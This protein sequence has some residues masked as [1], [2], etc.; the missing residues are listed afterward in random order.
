MPT[1]LPGRTRTECVCSGSSAAICAAICCLP[2]KYANGGRN[3]EPVPFPD[4]RA[5]VLNWSLARS[6]WI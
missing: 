2:P 1:H 4:K 3:V 5:A 6:W